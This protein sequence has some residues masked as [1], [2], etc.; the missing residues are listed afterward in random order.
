MEHFINTYYTYTDLIPTDLY[1]IQYGEEQCENGH[2]FGPCIRS[3]YLLHYIYSGRGILKINS[4]E[5]QLYSGQMFL[6][7]PHQLAYYRADYEEPWLYRWVEFNGSMSKH[8]LKNAGLSKSNPIFTDT[9]DF[10]AAKALSKLIDAKEQPFSKTMQLLWEFVDSLYSGVSQNVQAFNT[11]YVNKAKLL[12]KNNI[13]KPITVN[14]ISEQIGITR[15][16]LS[17]L[18]QKREGISI[19]QYIL[20]LKMNTAAMY[21]KN[22]SISITAAAQS[23]G[24][25]DTHVFNKAFKRHFGT[26]PTVWRQ[27]NKWEQSILTIE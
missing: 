6:I 1:P 19:Q 26:S 10:T 13:H 20:S 11:D 17:R 21:L 27:K 8:I 4:V 24:Y 18:F 7:S 23:V 14:Y 15:N 5:Y 3:N 2:S 22:Q 12:V 9:A 25:Y 16:Y